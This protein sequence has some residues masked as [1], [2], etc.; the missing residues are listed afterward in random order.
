MCSLYPGFAASSLMSSNTQPFCSLWPGTHHED[1]FTAPSTGQGAFPLKGFV[2]TAPSAWDALPVQVFAMASCLYSLRSLLMYLILWE[3][4]PVYVSAHP[5][6]WPLGAFVLLHGIHHLCRII[7][8]TVSLLF[9][10]PPVAL[11]RSA[12]GFCCCINKT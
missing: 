7:S 8:L 1:A 12:C 10:P 6:L 2:S 5:S 11:H 3:A 9:L 4:C